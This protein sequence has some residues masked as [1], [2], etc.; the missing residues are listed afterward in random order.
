MDKHRVFQLLRGFFLAFIL[1]WSGSLCMAAGMG[2]TPPSFLWAVWAVVAA[3]LTLAVTLGSWTRL[4][5]VPALAFLIPVRVPAALALPGCLAALGVCRTVCLGKGIALAGIPA[6]AGLGLCLVRPEAAP[7]REALFLLLTGEGILLITAHTRFQHPR[8]GNRLTLTALPVLAVVFGAILFL[9]PQKSYVNRSAEIQRSLVR[10]FPPAQQF[11]AELPQVSPASAP[12]QIIL[13]RTPS[14]P[15]RQAVMTVTA[16]ESG[17]LYLRQRSYDRYDGSTWSASEG[18]TEVF[19]APGTEPHPLEIHTQ[20]PQEQLLTTYYPVDGVTLE[21]GAMENTQGLTRYTV[22]YT[23][24]IPG[25]HPAADLSR[26]LTLPGNTRRG[27]E[28]LLEPL[29]AD[30]EETG[31]KVAAIGDFLRRGQYNLSPEPIPEGGDFVLSFLEG[32]IEGSCTHFAA[33]GAVLL[34]SAGVPARLAVGYL[35]E[36]RANTAVTVTHGGA[37]A[38]VEYY[39]PDLN[40]WKILDPTPSGDGASPT[41]NTAPVSA[42]PR[43]NYAV[44]LPAL[45]L[46][47][48]LFRL[49]RGCRRFRLRRLDSNAKALALWQEAQLASRLLGEP[50]SR[51]LA[52][53][54][55][56]ARFSPHR[57]T[58]G[59][60]S[61]F[62]DALEQ[63][64]SCL[65]KKF[66]L[67][68]LVHRWVYGVY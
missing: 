21:G 17:R 1:S 58:E 65:K 35:V 60:L 61:V 41:E 9:N 40:I 46:P 5:A 24:P 7:S 28:A 54:A 45:L 56:K 6:L 31:E 2:I 15:T 49:R 33:A 16:R 44:L 53:L 32:E 37:H 12:A 8:Q 20:V 25:A 4:L 36:A 14:E 67:K 66:F 51:E 34:R 38:W 63:S 43:Q 29:L 39:D 55:R 26:Y 11:F 62:E 42:A 47:E 59:E 48:V 27:A 30:R 18:L 23:T 57:L 10:L 64:R 13:N 50:V 22:F 68:R 3:V 52:A 19:F